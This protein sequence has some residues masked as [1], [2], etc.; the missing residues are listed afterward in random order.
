M[1]MTGTGGPAL[2]EDYVGNFMPT[3]THPDGNKAT[4]NGVEVSNIRTEYR[5]TTT[6]L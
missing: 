3:Q 6:S 4:S 2:Y 1:A 5:Y